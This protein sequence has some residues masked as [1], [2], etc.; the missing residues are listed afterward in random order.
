MKSVLLKVAVVAAVA[1]CVCGS[2]FRRIGKDLS[3]LRTRLGEKR[4]DGMDVDFQPHPLPCAFSITESIDAWQPS[5]S[6]F[7]QNLYIGL[8]NTFLFSSEDPGM[9]AVQQILFR[10]DQRL[11][12]PNSDKVFIGYYAAANFINADVNNDMVEEAA[13]AE[14]IHGILDEY[15]GEWTFFNV[16]EHAEFHGK[17][18]KMYYSFDVDDNLDIYLFA[19]KDNYILG[20]NITAPDQTFK[21]HVVMTYVWDF[22][23]SNLV[24]NQT[25]FGTCN[26]TRAFVPPKESPCKKFP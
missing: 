13:A 2:S 17:P 26:D 10:S 9:N 16:T 7:Q 8:N 5:Q 11:K 6:D 3:L 21:E 14:D 22:P 18:C 12:D 25:L 20:L 4:R 23:L 1:V 15:E 19:D 24:L